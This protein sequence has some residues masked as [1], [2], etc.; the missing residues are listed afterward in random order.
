M[1]TKHKVTLW[2]HVCCKTKN[3]PRANVMLIQDAEQY[4]CCGM[5]ML[6]EPPSTS[7][8]I[9]H[10]IKSPVVQKLTKQAVENKT[11]FVDEFCKFLNSAMSGCKD[12]A[13]K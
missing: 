8:L 7:V 3:V 9:G 5:R 2:C 13:K 1:P 11:S 6:E 4:E 10:W 12:E